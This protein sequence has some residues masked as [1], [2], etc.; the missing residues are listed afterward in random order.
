HAPV[1]VAPAVAPALAAPASAPAPVPAS[2]PASVPA[3]APAP[4]PAAA[5]AKA[6]T[7]PLAAHAEANAE[8]TAEANAK[9][10]GETGET[11][12]QWGDGYLGG[13]RDA[14]ELPVDQ[15]L[16]KITDTFSGKGPTTMIR[17]DYFNDTISWVVEATIRYQLNAVQAQQLICYAYARSAM[18]LHSV[19]RLLV[20]DAMTAERAS[21]VNDQLLEAQLGNGHRFFT[22]SRNRVTVPCPKQRPTEPDD[23]VLHWE[24]ISRPA[25]DIFIA[26]KV[27]Q[28]PVGL[29]DYSDTFFD[30][31]GKIICVTEK[32]ENKPC[33]YVN[34]WYGFAQTNT[35]QPTN[36]FTPER[37]E[38][39]K[40]YLH[41]EAKKSIK[42]LQYTNEGLTHFRCDPMPCPNNPDHPP[43]WDVHWEVIDKK[44]FK[45]FLNATTQLSM[46]AQ[47]KFVERTVTLNSC[48]ITQYEDEEKKPDKRIQTY[49]GSGCKRNYQW[50][51][52]AAL[53]VNEAWPQPP[54][55][56]IAEYVDQS[57]KQIP[58]LYEATYNASATYE[59]MT[60]I[61]RS[62]AVVLAVANNTLWAI[63]QYEETIVAQE[64]AEQEARQAAAHSI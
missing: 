34:R 43:P 44:A 47:V 20:Y 18:M 32:R 37:I 17:D 1:A 61:I 39:Y 35:W 5:A 62:A 53:V 41:S 46:P 36:Y 25:F 42:I 57:S 31:R 54:D 49:V 11:K 38:K 56:T 48:L 29:L 28:M 2:A 24:I 10:N 23:Q 63:S 22:C 4:A 59:D 52:D 64:K 60:E 14:A 30:K 19:I 33:N 55:R 8:A 26:E 21:D 27:P 12:P 45:R 58:R 13:F 50:T 7:A 15:D 9:A 16:F 3:I 40:T 6:S 51:G